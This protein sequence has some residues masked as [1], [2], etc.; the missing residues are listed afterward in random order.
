MTI[1]R[2]LIDLWPLITEALESPQFRDINKEFLKAFSW[3]SRDNKYGMYIVSNHKS[4]R[5]HPTIFIELTSS[6]NKNLIL[7]NNL[8]TSYKLADIVNSNII[9]L[10]NRSKTYG[11]S[12][13]YE[14]NL[15]LIPWEDGSNLK[16]Y[17]DLIGT[18]LK[19]ESVLQLYRHDIHVSAM[20]KELEGDIDTLIYSLKSIEAVTDSCNEVLDFV[21]TYLMKK[22][23]EKEILDNKV[24]ENLI[25]WQYLKTTSPN[26]G[27]KLC[28]HQPK[29][30]LQRIYEDNQ[31]R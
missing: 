17:A 18:F 19:Y 14:S 4:R 24:T 7:K 30:M 23:Y 1:E 22:D 27:S 2:I 16:M 29:M 13:N 15:H 5:P 21:K 6:W 12:V 25:W 11:L 31:L 20:Q 28:P 8:T 26:V 3:Y 10:E 9:C